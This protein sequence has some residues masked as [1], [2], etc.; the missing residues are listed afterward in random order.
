MNNT[1][2]VYFFI[3]VFTILIVLRNFTRLIS[4]LLQ[5]N[6]KPLILSNRE[7]IILGLSISYLTTYIINE[8]L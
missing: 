8:L 7:L 5:S 2:S 6:P 3:F 4:T 1:D